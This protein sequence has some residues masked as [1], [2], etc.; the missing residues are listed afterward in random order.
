MRLLVPQ[1]E[2]L[3]LC[4]A[5]PNVFFL[6]FDHFW[7]QFSINKNVDLLNEFVAALVIFEA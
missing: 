5:N 4:S 2:V 1:G 3:E 7:P 6:V